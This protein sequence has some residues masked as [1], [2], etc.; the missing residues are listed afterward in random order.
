MVAPNRL[1]TTAA[2]DTRGR[3]SSSTVVNPLGDGQN[4]T[5]S[6]TYDDRWDRPITITSPLVGVARMEYDA[7]N[8]NVLWQQ[9]GD[10]AARRVHYRYYTSG[11]AVGQL[12]A[13][14][15]PVTAGGFAPRDS[16]VYDAQGNLRMTVSPVGFLTLHERDALGRDTLTITPIDSATATTEANL[17]ASGVRQ[18]TSYDVMDRVLTTETIGPARVHSASTDSA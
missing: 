5:T 11:A 13:V 14:Q 4:A 15:S 12:R 3:V 8:G 17:R 16:L 2:Y 1:K 10:D 18:R 7:T 9:Q 6:Y